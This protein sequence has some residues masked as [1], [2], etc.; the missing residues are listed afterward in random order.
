[1]STH[2]MTFLPLRVTSLRTVNP[3]ASLMT[4]S[5]RRT[6]PALLYIL[7]RKMSCLP[8]LVSHAPGQRGIRQQPGDG[9]LDF[10]HGTAVHQQAGFPVLHGVGN[11]P[12]TATYNRLPH[13][14]RFKQHDS[15]TLHVARTL[16][17]I[18]HDEY[19]A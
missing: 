12:G 18:G 7:P 5:K 13:P 15:E 17:P 6:E 9:F 8:A 3:S 2:L 19:A 4:I 14:P 11:P 16:F 1:M 10:G